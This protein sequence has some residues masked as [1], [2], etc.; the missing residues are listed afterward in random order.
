MCFAYARTFGMP[1]QIVRCFNLYGPR[2]KHFG[3]GGVISLFMRRAMRGEPLIVYGDG[4][5]SRDYTYI[6]DAVGFYRVLLDNW[7]NDKPFNA[8]TGQDITINELA[9]KINDICGTKSIIVH[10]K[11]RPSEVKRLCCDNRQAMETG[12]EPLVSLDDGLRNLYEWFKT[13]GTDPR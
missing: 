3:Y 11:E 6:T 13:N 2:Q 8:G 1:I 10:T 9:G 12:W 4:K 5:Q 7:L